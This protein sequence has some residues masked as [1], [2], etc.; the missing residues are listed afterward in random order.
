MSPRVTSTV[1]DSDRADVGSGQVF[2][3]PGR[4]IRSSRP[5][6]LTRASLTALARRVVSIGA[7]IAADVCGLALGLYVALVIREVFVG[8][9]PPL[10]GLLWE[11]ETNWLPFLTLVTVLVFWQRG[12]YDR[13][14]RRA[15]FGKVL[16]SVVLVALITLAFA[17]GTGH[18]FNTFGLVPTATL[19]TAGF[20]GL[21]RASYETVTGMLMQ[22]LGVRR[23]VLL[24]GSPPEVSHL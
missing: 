3:Q 8:H 22:Q 2:Q 23:R 17:L 20:I 16:A 7:L 1:S 14:E 15:G 5:Y 13:R 12:L 24:I 19:V 10:W 9:V 21:F 4:D 18:E 11:A 6:F